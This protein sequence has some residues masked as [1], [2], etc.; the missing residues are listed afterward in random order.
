MPGE[1]IAK[2]FRGTCEKYGDKKIALRYKNL[3]IW[4]PY[5]WK[6]WWE[7][8]KYFALGLISLGFRP[9][10][11]ITI[12][13]DNEPEWYFAQFA[14][15]CAGGIPTGAY[16]DSLPAEIKYVIVQSGSTFVV[17]EDQEQVDKVLDIKAEIPNVKKV[18]YWDP[19]GLK[20]Y[21]DSIL[22]RFDQVV[23]LGRDYD[24]QHPGLLEQIIEK[25]EPEDPVMLTYS[26]GTTGLPKGIVHCSRSVLAASRCWDM[27]APTGEKDEFVSYFPLAYGAEFLYMIPAFIRGGATVNFPEEMET[28]Q[29]DIRE[30]GPTKSSSAPRL[31]ENEVSFVQVKIADA[32]LFK[33]LA[34][35]LFMPVGYKIARMKLRSEKVNLFW[36]LVYALGY[37]VLFRP[38]KDWLAY[39]GNR[40]LLIGGASMAAEVFEFFVALGIDARMMYGMIE[41]TPTAMHM[42]DDIDPETSGV[43]TPDSELRISEGGEILSRG[44]QR[45]LGYHNNPEATAKLIDAQGWVHTGDAGFITERGHLVCID[46][47]ADLGVLADGTG[48]SPSYIENK[49]K[50]SPYIRDAVITGDDRNFVGALISIDFPN[51]GQWA[52]MHRIPYT[53]FVDLSQKPEVYELIKKDIMAINRRLPERQRI[54][55]FALLHKELDADDAEL[56]RTRKLRR[57]EVSQR[58]HDMIEALYSDRMEYTAEAKVTYRDGRT[59]T[60]TTKVR[61]ATVEDRPG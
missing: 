13:G 50:F 17:V 20:F 25:S 19:K 27:P 2:L 41:C 16:Q 21:D 49:L 44:P 26:S 1:T 23:M 34:Y 31:L 24:R 11:R 53:T 54:R 42:K 22:M 37:V 28:I 35:Q 9:G 58:Y 59:A 57:K 18:I 52:E 45:M 3:G 55:R 12:I 51:L 32:S 29:V 4:Q 14:A 39:S 5:T 38:I 56:T 8:S 30:I 48:F 40:V 15:I 60:I 6:D 47:L 7:Q 43:P 36:R 10:D 46:R 61:I 33:R